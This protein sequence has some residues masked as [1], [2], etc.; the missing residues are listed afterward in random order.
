MLTK[1]VAPKQWELQTATHIATQTATHI[2]TQTATHIAT[3]T[4]T[5][6]ATHGTTAMRVGGR[7]SACVQV[8]TGN[9]HT[10]TPETHAEIVLKHIKC[11]NGGISGDEIGEFFAPASFFQFL[12]Q[13]LEGYSCERK[14]A[15]AR[16]R[17]R[18]IKRGRVMM[19]EYMCVR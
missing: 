4:A 15:C 19:G 5:H 18:E 16:E 3:Q 17:E 12:V 10:Y 9:K 13:L 1:M 6:T 11:K 7:E 8:R 2:A 14:I